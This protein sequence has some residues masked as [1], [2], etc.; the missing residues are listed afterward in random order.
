MARQDTS[1]LNLFQGDQQ[2]NENPQHIT[3]YPKNWITVT[4]AGHVME[5]DNSKDGERIRIINGATGS[6]FEM[7]EESH[8]GGQSAVVADKPD[9]VADSERKVLSKMFGPVHTTLS[10]E[11]SEYIFQQGYTVH[12]DNLGLRY[13]ASVDRPEVRIYEDLVSVLGLNPP[14]ACEDVLTPVSIAR[15]ADG[16]P[17]ERGTVDLSDLQPKAKRLK[18][19]KP[20]H[21]VC[22]TKLHYNPLQKLYQVTKQIRLGHPNHLTSICWMVLPLS[23]MEDKHGGQPPTNIMLKGLVMS[24][25][26]G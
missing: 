24:L 5:F 13:L 25:D 26:L 23:L 14:S 21:S 1:Q 6:I 22:V 17:I 16:T 4:S 3:N 20:V 2:E 9:F 12:Y 18:F 10:V 7:D 11:L 8:F 19:W 15:S